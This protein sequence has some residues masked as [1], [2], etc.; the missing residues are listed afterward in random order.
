MASHRR[1]HGKPG[2]GFVQAVAPAFGSGRKLPSSDEE[3]K[4]RVGAQGW[5]D[6]CA[7]DHRLKLRV[8]PPIL[9]QVAEGSATAGSPGRASIFRRARLGL[10][11]TVVT[12]DSDFAAADFYLDSTIF[13]FPIALGAFLRLHGISP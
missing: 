11:R 3:G 10:L 4:C 6:G 12:A 2:I 7:N 5:S 9:L 13:D 1:T 8:G